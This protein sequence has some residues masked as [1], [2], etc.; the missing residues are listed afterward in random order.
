MDASTVNGQPAWLPPLAELN[1]Y[2]GNWAVYEAA[3]YEYFRTDFIT[4]TTRFRT[5][6]VRL[7]RMPLYE[8]KEASY[9]HCI[10][11][12]KDEKERIPDMRRCERIR[13]P[14]PCIEHERELKV[15]TEVRNNEERMHLWLESEG[16]VVVLAIRGTYLLLWTTFFVQHQHERDKFTRRYLEARKRLMPPR[17]T[18]S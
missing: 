2:G 10:S 5:L 12:G 11:T 13:W 16:Y 3:L 1:D 4:H 15:W 18:A 17:G 8:N 14:R 7:K 6:P 9:W